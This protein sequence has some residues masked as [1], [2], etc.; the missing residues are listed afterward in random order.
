[1]LVVGLVLYM[2]AMKLFGT[3]MISDCIVNYGITHSIKHVEVES[4]ESY[5]WK[6]YNYWLD[7]ILNYSPTDG[8]VSRN[9]YK[10]IDRSCHTRLLRDAHYSQ[11]ANIY[12]ESSSQASEGSGV[13]MQ[14]IDSSL[15]L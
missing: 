13:L 11:S 6:H 8:M 5:N 12:I 2:K 1:M 15:V 3:D 4:N 9:F 10:F 14:V 7:S